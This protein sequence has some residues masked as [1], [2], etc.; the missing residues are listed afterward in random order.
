MAGDLLQ[1]IRKARE[2]TVKVD[3]F[4]FTIRRPTDAEAANV[5]SSG[6]SVVDIAKDYTV[7]WSNVKDSDLVPS[8][9]SD[10][11]K[12]DS[13]LWGEWVSDRP[14]FWEPIFNAIVGV[15]TRHQDE[16]EKSGKI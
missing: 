6:P 11:V 7:G 8:G 15:Y 16:L 2:S 1:R 14:D 3:K 9:G 12:F 13:E 10:D 4:V 5:F